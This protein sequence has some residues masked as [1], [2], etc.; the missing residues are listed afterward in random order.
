MQTHFS[1]VINRFIQC[2]YFEFRAYISKYNNHFSFG[3]LYLFTVQEENMNRR[4]FH[5]N[6]LLSLNKT[7]RLASSRE[8]ALY[9]IRNFMCIICIALSN[10]QKKIYIRIC[11]NICI[12]FVAN[13]NKATQTISSA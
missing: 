3:K 11:S 6:A 7:R 4:F 10:T 9:H 1:F 2:L 12:F 13:P 8:H 5:T